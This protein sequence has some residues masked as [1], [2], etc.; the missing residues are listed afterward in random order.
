MSRSATR[1]CGDTRV[2]VNQ[3]G[4]PT[5][6]LS[7]YNSSDFRGVSGSP[8]TTQ[9]SASGVAVTP[10]NKRIYVSGSFEVRVFDAS[11]MKQAGSIRVGDTPY[12]IAFSPDGSR[13]FVAI[14]GDSAVSVIDTA[15]LKQVSTIGVG[16]WPL[17]VAVTPDG[18]QLWVGTSEAVRSPCSMRS[19]CSSSR[20]RLSA[21]SA[22][23][24]GW[25]PPAMAG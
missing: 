2:Y 15:A 3:S 24:S 8:A 23:R 9:G 20:V 14:A 21:L 16:G 19:R 10:D 7:G 11:N 13:A 1:F 6:R 25:R 18:K 12:G 4:F 22:A 5:G 17:S